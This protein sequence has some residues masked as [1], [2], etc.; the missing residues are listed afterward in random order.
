MR[1]KMYPTINMKA[2]GILLRQI[3]EQKNM[4]VKDVQRYLNLSCVQS[5]YRWLSGRS[6]PSIDNLYALSELFQ[7]P[8]DDMIVGNRIYQFPINNNPLYFRMKAYYKG[9]LGC[10]TA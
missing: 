2:T 9:I 6:M 8:I 3:M 5:V 1:Y 4:S 10:C 7:M